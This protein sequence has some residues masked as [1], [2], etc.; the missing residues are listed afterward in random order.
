MA[1]LFDAQPM[2]DE[3]PWTAVLLA[4]RRPGEDAFALSHGVA[5]KALIEVGGEPML[6]RVVRTLLA[7]P[8]VG[9]IVVLAQE[10]EALAA[11][12]LA[13]LNEE[14]RLGFARSESGIS[15]SILSIAGRAQAPWPL[16]VVTA[17]HALL[18][19]PMVAEF[20]AGTGDADASV[21]VVERKVVEAA[22]P[23]TRRTWLKFSDG[24]YTGA[25]MFA[26]KRPAAQTALRIWA[27]VERDRKKALKLL[28]RFGPWLALRALTR[29]ISLSAALDAAGRRAGMTVSAVR[30]SIAEAA[31]D[32][33]KDADL[34]LARAIVARRS[35][36]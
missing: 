32:V 3:R 29:T 35:A 23:E 11:G 8:P 18:T 20:L 22:Y 14:P 25:N 7:S 24:H 12:P 13:W 17:D 30:L 16:L 2:S 34:E 10:P 5:A 28:T 27:E 1:D 15:T 36:Q 9:R 21:A 31:I 26:L 4:G 19:P 6:G 33:D